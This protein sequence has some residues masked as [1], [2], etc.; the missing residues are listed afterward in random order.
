MT[1]KM[2]LIEKILARAANVDYVEAGDIIEVNVDWCMIHDVTGP[3]AIK[4]FY[5]IGVEKVWNPDRIVVVFD[6]YSVAPTVDAANLHKYVR[7]FVKKYGIRYFYDVGIGICHQVM[8]EYGHVTPGSVI[9]GADSHSTTYGALG[10][11]STGMGSTD[12]AA[13]FA[14]GK[15]WIEVPRTFRIKLHRK[16]NDLVTGKDIIL[17]LLGRHGVT[18]ALNMAVEFTG[19]TINELTISDRLTI[20]NMTVEMGA[21]AAIIEPDEKTLEYVKSRAKGPIVMLK[22]DDVPVEKYDEIDISSIEPMVALPHS[23]DNVKP[24][25]E[26]SN[27]EID[28]AFIGSCTNGRLE[29]LEIAA[30]ILRGRK[31]KSDVRLIVIPASV[32]VYKEALRRGIINDLIDAGAIIGNPSCGP[33]FGGH[34]GVIGDDEV[35]IS[36]SNR[37]FIGRMGSK[38]GRIYLASPATVAASAITGKITDPREVI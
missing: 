12:L 4:A 30:R 20:C 21:A 5:E 6:H 26:L 18:G 22:G 16:L 11:F 23:P 3:L 8:V 14:T 7:E 17:F 34:L 19:E 31:V 25:S 13:I 37:N 10:A 33:C 15:I 28:E 29:D 38:K 36:A 24:A 9:V 2:G 35:V 1:K 27:I 32:N